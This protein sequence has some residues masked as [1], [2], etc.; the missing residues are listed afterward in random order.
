M[1]TDGHFTNPIVNKLLFDW[2]TCSFKVQRTSSLIWQSAEYSTFSLDSESSNYTLHVTGY[3]GDAGD[4]LLNAAVFDWIANGKPFSTTD[5]ENGYF[6]CA[7]GD[8]G[9]WYGRCSTSA[10]TVVEAAAFWTTSSNPVTDVVSSHMMI[11][12]IQ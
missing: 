11:R 6:P 7:T 3:S 12:A 8:G 9:W 5:R 10:L 4:A 1:D 2:I